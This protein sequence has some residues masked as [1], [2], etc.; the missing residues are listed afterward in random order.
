MCK[1]ARYLELLDAAG[2]HVAAALGPQTLQ[3]HI[4]ERTGNVMVSVAC[5]NDASYTH[6]YVQCEWPDMEAS[7]CAGSEKMCAYGRYMLR[8]YSP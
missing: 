8:H 4:D 1:V 2:D 6:W 7:V 3:G 5:S